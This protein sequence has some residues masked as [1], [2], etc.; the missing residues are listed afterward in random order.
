MNKFYKRCLPCTHEL[1]ENYPLLLSHFPSLICCEVLGEFCNVVNIITQCKRLKYFRF[2]NYGHLI[3]HP[4]FSSVAPNQCLQHLRVS[5]YSSDIGDIFMDSVSAHRGLESVD[6]H[7][8]SVTVTGITTIIQNSPKLYTFVVT[9]QQIVDENNIK[10]D[11][12]VL[13]DNLKI[14]FLHRKLFNISGLVLK[15]HSR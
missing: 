15:Y 12:E 1:H 3:L 7:I 4:L 14:K 2:F 11:P 6:L 5:S 8:Q 10:I 13:K 9:T